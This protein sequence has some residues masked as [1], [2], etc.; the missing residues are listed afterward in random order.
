MTHL[1]L[2]LINPDEQGRFME[3]KKRGILEADGL[4]KRQVG[5]DWDRIGCD[6]AG[7]KPDVE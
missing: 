3:I 5:P 1:A 6:G 4:E 2:R 7:Q